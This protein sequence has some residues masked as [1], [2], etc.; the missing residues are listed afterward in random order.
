MRMEAQLVSPSEPP[1]SSMT[2]VFLDTLKSKISQSAE[3]LTRSY[4][5]SKPSNTPMSTVRFAH[6]AG[7]QEVKQWL[8]MQTIQRPKNS[9]R[10]NEKEI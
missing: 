1:T 3:T 8:L 10:D 9:S 2:K 5:L 7:S 6:Q 4:V